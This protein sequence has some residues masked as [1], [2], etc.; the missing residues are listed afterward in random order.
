MPPEH[1]F[2]C[3]AAAAACARCP[4]A[5]RR[6]PRGAAYA[7]TAALWLC[8]FGSHGGPAA[9]VQRCAGSHSA[10]RLQPGFPPSASLPPNPS[11]PPS[12]LLV[13]PTSSAQRTTHLP[14][15]ALAPACTLFPLGCPSPQ[16][17]SAFGPQNE[18]PTAPC[19]PCDAHAS[20][21]SPT[22]SPC[23]LSAPTRSNALSCHTSAIFS[24]VPQA[25]P[26]CN[27]APGGPPFFFACAVDTPFQ[28]AKT[29]AVCNSPNARSRQH[30]ALART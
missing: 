16:S 28:R 25:A 15:R 27:L 21:F 18:C 6:L 11:P 8:R 9:A 1:A 5:T 19:L 22:L 7:G 10:C 2:S 13:S 23:C 20:A 24:T 29:R 3:C 26:A 30:A 12:L 4:R 14:L 17:P